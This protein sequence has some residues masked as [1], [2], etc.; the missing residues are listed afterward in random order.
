MK[1]ARP[2]VV[3]LLCSLVALLAFVARSAWAST[4]ASVATLP[5]KVQRVV[6]LGDSITHAGFHA[7]CVESYFLTRH[8]GR[9]IEFINVGLPSE[10]VSGLSEDGHANGAFPRPVLNERLARVL[11]QT[12]P[13]LV[14]ACYGMNDGI[15]LPHDAARARAFEDGIRHLRAT[16][17]ASG[18]RMLHLTPPPF[19]NV[20]G[21]NPHYTGVLERYSAWLV[22]RRADG[23]D[24]A[25]INTAVAREL[26]AQR[27]KDP[28][29]LFAK[30]GVHLDERGQWVVARALLRH[31][32]AGDLPNTL[33][34]QD[35]FAAHPNG[36]AVMKLVR[37][38]ASL[39]K[40]AWL[41]ATGHKR[42]M[43]AGLSLDEARMRA[44]KIDAEIR[45]LLASRAQ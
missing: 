42:P 5:A 14:I 37:T 19:D 22:A 35:M 17:L 7:V 1:R 16:V 18:T 26:A 12:K 29:F 38:R 27:A 24:V 45:A 20:K 33:E 6:F 13:D 30:D 28:A 40:D 25:D 34:A 32:G 2:S 41:T 44:A 21:D 9:A 4:P 43:K 10:T 15:Y 31:L 8:P 36:P 3:P 23:W 39:M 11:A